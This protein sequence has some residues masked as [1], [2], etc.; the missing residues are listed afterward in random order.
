MPK[1][2]VLFIASPFRTGRAIRLLTNNKYNHVALSLTPDTQRLY[3]FSRYRYREPL[4]SGF[5]IEYTDRYE[6]YQVDIKVCEIP[7]TDEQL[8]SIKRRLRLYEMFREKTRYNFMDIV[9]YPFHKHIDIRLTHTCIS[10]VLEL[11]RLTDVHT[12]G[13]LEKKLTGSDVYEGR[14]SAFEKTATHGPVDFFER[15]PRLTVARE[16]GATMLALAG[17]FSMFCF[18]RFMGLFT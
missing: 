7:V 17:T 10:F 9:A 2:Y 4:L 16:S 18:D 15:R 5:G 14:L 1:V 6:P 8:A 12:I 11:L 3:A 13:G